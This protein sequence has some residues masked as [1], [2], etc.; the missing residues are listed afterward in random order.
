MNPVLIE[1][2]PIS[3]YWYSI[4]ILIAILLGSY[5]F[6]HKAKKAGLEENFYT[7]LVFYGIII[8]IIGARLYYVLFNLNYYIT[9]PLEI[10]AVWNGGLAIHGGIIAGLIWF[11]Y[12]SKK[13]KKNIFKILDLAAPSLILAQAIGRW[14]NF[15]NSEAHGGVVSKEHLSSIGVPDFI[16][17]GMHIN[18]KYYHPTFFYE[19]FF[20]IIGFILLI[21]LGKKKNIKSGQIFGTYLIYYS[22]VR[23]IIESFRTDSLMLGIFKQAQIISIVLLLLGILILVYNLDVSKIKKLKRK[24]KKIIKK[25]LRRIINE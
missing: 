16:I 17:N 13:H 10:L 4:F 23:F 14:G 3:I 15:F 25:I 7:N 19:S 24:V 21:L 12:Y 8:G 22:I 11:V 2:G 6:F 5:L 9:H 20:D 1:I 18:G